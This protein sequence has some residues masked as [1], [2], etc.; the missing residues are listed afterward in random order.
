MP[1]HCTR[2]LLAL[3]LAA[4]AAAVPAQ[5]AGAA[6]APPEVGR[7]VSASTGDA[8]PDPIADKQQALREQALA[9]VLKGEA[10]TERIGE[11]TV[12]K[13]GTTASADQAPAA[14]RRS[15]GSAA[16]GPADQYVE[17][18]REDTDQ[19]FVL[20]VEFGDE[21]DPAYPDRDTSAGVP[22]PT[23][24]DGPRFNA[25]PQPDRRVDNS[26]DWNADYDRDYYED[27]Y[28]GDGAVT[29]RES[30][31]Q[32][33][34]QQSSGRYSVDGLVTE[35]VRVPFN[36][37]RYGR[38]NG[39]PCAGNVCSNTWQLVRDGMA[40]WHASQVAAG[41][42]PA[43]IAATLAR[44]DVW[45]RYDKDGDGNFDEPD[46][47]LDH[48]QIV[49]AG[50]DQADGDPYQGEDA[51]WSHRW[52][53]FQ[54]T[55]PSAPY[56]A[57]GGTQIGATG[58]WAAD[59][60]IQP[61]NGGLSVVAHEFGH[62]LGL[63]DLYDRVAPSGVDNPVSWWS[64]MAQSRVSAAGDNAIGSRAADLGPWE[65]MQLGWLD[66]DVVAP[67]QQRTLE[68]GPHEYNSDKP[69]A[70]AVVLPDKQVVTQIGAP[71]SGQRQWWSGSDDDD[72]ATMTRRV[73]LP[74][75]PASLA[76]KAR[77]NIEDCGADPCDYAYV[78]VD[79]GSGWKAVPGSI[80]KPAEGNGI[81]GLQATWV[82]ATFDLS[83][84]A[85]KEI[86]LRVR[87]AT[88][89]ATRGQDPELPAGIFVDDVVVTAGGTVVLEDGAEGTSG[90]TLAGFTVVGSSRTTAYDQFY[91]ASNRQYVRFDQYLRTGPYNFSFP[92][93]P[94]LAEHFPYQDGL[95]VWYWNTSVPDNDTSA[96]PGEGLIL[97]VD[98]HAR[99]VY[100]LEG[101][102]WR[103]RIQT[104]DAPFGLERTDSFT[105]RLN[106]R[107]NL[108]RGQAGV[109]TFDDSE[110]DRY[111]KPEL[112]ANGVR[113][114][115][116]GTRIRVLEEQGTSVRIRVISPAALA[117]P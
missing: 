39:F 32:Y 13:V 99:T 103:G 73:T 16:D 49:H 38:S 35:V 12:V 7:A 100:N 65:K 75:G 110:R 25:I 29:G 66:Y 93:R 108:V 5:A 54:G 42:T 43:Q 62:D 21:R 91:L 113:V 68:L 61:E 63:P 45:D 106:G 3:A 31:R 80:T 9:A 51:I 94:D 46:G 95:L 58:I 33:Y 82:P 77:W 15:A 109:P 111:F 87:Y 116:T 20:L 78:E 27:L 107:P 83:A 14:A 70:V 55:N 50:G 11:S 71:A 18:S 19:L 89:G 117:Q 48:L 17:L 30:M 6:P 81:D 56:P 105:L 26:T 104:Y 10:T 2:L 8:L 64:L 96:H 22:G 1:T 53:A 28:F 85:G 101:R 88:D 79:D 74:S 59:Y 114:A 57:L 115:G 34:E 98:A 67:G 97:P 86:G 90:W 23:V 36:E 69:Q 37:A 102:P 60:T 84:Y 72:T 40:A 52:R 92:D 76:F 41:Q 24:F 4:G 44:Y 47:Y 112:P